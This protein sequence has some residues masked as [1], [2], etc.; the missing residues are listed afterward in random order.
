LL[1]I[2][3][4]TDLHITTDR[5]PVNR[6]RNAERLSQVLKSIHALKPRPVAIIA[7]GDL[8]D[9]GEPEEYAELVELLKSVEIPIYFG[10]GNHDRRALFLAA[11]TSQGVRTDPNG[12]IQYAVDLGGL[13]LVVCD[14]LDDASEGGAFCEDRAAWLAATLD[15]AP[16]QPTVIALH[17]PPIASGIRW[18][19]PDPQA[20]WIARLGDV[21]RD[22]DQVKSLLCGHVHRAFNGVLAGRAVAAAPATSIQLTLDLTP[23]DMHVPDGREMLVEE[24]PGF[25]VVMVHEGQVNTHVCVAGDYAPAVAYTSPFIRS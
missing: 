14:T 16:L 20:G 10:I 4:I 15:E 9:R 19:D 8:V 12:F 25:T 22:R 24:P 3:Q 23:V 6:W 1:T 11:L 13:R 18:M 7:S 5:D 17:H 2:A 21:I